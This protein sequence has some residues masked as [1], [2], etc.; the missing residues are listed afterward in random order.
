MHRIELVGVRVHLVVLPL[1]GLVL[2]VEA[3]VRGSHARV[4]VVPVKELDELEI[5]P[6]RGL[7]KEERGERA[8]V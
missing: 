1:A 7:T 4:V 3:V 8:A 6:R 5:P 2:H